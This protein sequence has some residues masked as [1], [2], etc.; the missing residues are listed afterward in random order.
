MTLQP[1][2]NSADYLIRRMLNR[3]ILAGLLVL[4]LLS[5]ALGGGPAPA[6]AYADPGTIAYVKFSTGD[7]HVFSPDG[8]GDRVLWTYPLSFVSPAFELAWRPDGRE[9]AFSS[10]HEAAC[11]WYDSD[12]YAIGYDGSGYRRVT[13]SP[14]CAGLAGL[15]K[16]SVTVNVSNYTTSL[17]WV[18]VQG[19]PAIQS[20][21]GGFM[22]TVTFN[23]VADLGPGVLQPPIGIYGH[24]RIPSY[25]PYADVQP[26]RTVAGGNVIF[27]S[28]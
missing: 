28:N 17:A 21:L 16:G 3:T 6:Q 24:Y 1:N 25:P 13:N 19:A 26:G 27:T 9:L 14:A 7:I 12:V 5:A 18:Y 20:V 15:P 10:D 22:G 2:H 8:T 23:D 11:S 4:I